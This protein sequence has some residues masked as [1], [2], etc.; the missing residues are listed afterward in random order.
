MIDLRRLNYDVLISKI[1][2]SLIGY[3]SFSFTRVRFLIIYRG[4]AVIVCLQWRD[5]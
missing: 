4:V 3:F 2:P 1:S 5:V